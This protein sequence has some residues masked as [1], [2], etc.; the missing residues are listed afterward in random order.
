LH[1][2]NINFT[3]K[4]ININ[5]FLDVNWELKGFNVECLYILEIHDKN[6][7]C[8]GTTK[9]EL[10]VIEEKIGKILYK[11]VNNSCLNSIQFVMEIK[12]IFCSYD[13]GYIIA[14]K[15]RDI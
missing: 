7:I 6:L 2:E 1:I 12:T 9:G 10:I 8:A 4:L 3:S 15:L 5:E 13:N 11:K 14:Y